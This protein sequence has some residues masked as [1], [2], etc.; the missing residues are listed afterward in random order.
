VID[1]PETVGELFA[2]IDVLGATGEGDEA[3][4]GKNKYVALA[5]H[6]FLCC[7]VLKAGDRILGLTLGTKSGKILRIHRF[8]F[9]R[10]LEKYSPGT[11]LWQVVLRHL[12]RQAEFRSVDMGYGTPAYRYRATNTIIQKGKVLLFRRSMANRCRILAHSGYSSAV[13]LLKA[14]RE[15]LSPE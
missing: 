15:G 5:E 8:F 13:N 12:I 3:V 4:L 7:F 6:G 11:T 1:S 14:R 2:A 10:N 9:D